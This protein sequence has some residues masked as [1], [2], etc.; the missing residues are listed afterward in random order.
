MKVEGVGFVFEENKGAKIR[1]FT[2]ISRQYCSFFTI[3][4]VRMP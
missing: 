2:A 1:Y 3:L 4:Q